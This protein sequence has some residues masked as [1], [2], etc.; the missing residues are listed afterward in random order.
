MKVSNYE[1]QLIVLK[2]ILEAIVRQHYSHDRR[3]ERLRNVQS[4]VDNYLN[5][6][7]YEGDRQSQGATL[8]TI[9]D[10]CIWT[11]D[12]ETHSSVK[13]RLR[14]ALDVIDVALIKVMSEAAKERRSRS[15]VE[16]S[17]DIVVDKGI[18]AELSRQKC[19]PLE[20]VL[21]E[22]RSIMFAY[23]KS[24]PEAI[25][26]FVKNDFEGAYAHL[27]IA[28]EDCYPEGSFVVVPEEKQDAR[29][30]ATVV[31]TWETFDAE[32]QKTRAEVLRSLA[33]ITGI[34]FDTIVDTIVKYQ[35]IH[36]VSF[37]AALSVFKENYL[38]G[39]YER[40]EGNDNT[41]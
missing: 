14:L 10:L 22:L 9:Y 27:K 30:L 37:H 15:S 11:L 16:S 3:N 36:N 13:S 2:T 17:Q 32:E 39:H 24:L 33:R 29:D 31:K 6:Q 34:D 12:Y 5:I 7:S 21:S 4:L 35:Q 28:H 8:K 23:N 40:K 19:I 20:T 26:E 41:D 38:S 1:T 25:A 18:A